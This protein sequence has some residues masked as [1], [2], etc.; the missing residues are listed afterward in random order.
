VLLAL[1]L[2]AL[3]TSDYEVPED[4]VVE[5]AA[6]VADSFIGLSFDPSG[7]PILSLERGGLL[8]LED[9]DGDGFFET[10]A[11]LTDAIAA[12]QGMYWTDGVLYAVGRVDG[13]Q[14]VHC[15]TPSAD[16][17]TIESTRLVAEVSGNGG[18]HG[19][20]AV[21]MGADGM[22][23]LMLGDHVRMTKDPVP[24]SPL[25][26][27]YEGARLPVLLDPR[28]HGHGVVYPGGFVARI[29]PASG[30]W[31]Y[32]SVGYRNAYDFAFDRNGELLT[33]DSDMEWGVGLP[34]YR[35]VRFIHSVPGGD[36]GWRKA[37]G[38][39]PSYYSDSLPALADAGRGSPTGVAYCTSE[40]F[41]ARYRD[42]LFAGDWT[43]GRIL[44]LRM[45][46][47]GAT[48]AGEVETIVS[49]NA[50][51]PVTDLAFG[52]DGALYFVSGGRG[53]VGRFER[54]VYGG[55]PGPPARGRPARRPNWLGVAPEDAAAVLS[56]SDPT[57]LRRALEALLYAEAVPREATGAICE[58][59]G[60]EDRFV[61]YA[62]M[63]V[64]RRHGTCAQPIDLRARLQHRIAAR[65]GD[66]TPS[67]EDE[68]LVDPTL[69]VDFLRAEQLRAADDAAQLDYLAELAILL[70]HSDGRV[71]R[72]LAVLLAALA[73]EGAVE[74]LLNALESEDDR[75]QQIHYAYCLSAIDA[76][77]TQS[78]LR[79]VL[80]WF[81][82]AERWTGGLSFP[83][84]LSAMRARITGLLSPEER[85]ELALKAP[86]KERVGLRTAV[87]LLEGLDAE[88][89]E[90]LVPAVQYAW[91]QADEEARLAAL[92]DLPVVSSP[93][94][95]GFLRRQ[96]ENVD[97]PR[98]AALKA[99]ARIGAADDYGRFV[100][101]LG[102]KSKDVRDAC[103][104]ALL[105]LDERPDDAAPFREALDHAR[106]LGAGRGLVYLQLFA[107]WA[108]EDVPDAPEDWNGTL[109]GWERWGAARFPGF[110]DEEVDDTRRPS[111]RFDQ[112]LA[113]LERSAERPGS[114][115]RGRD[116]F[117]RATCGSCHVVASYSSPALTGFGPDLMGV[118]RRFPLRDM[119]ETIVFPSKAIA[120]LYQTSV[121]VTHEGDVYEGRRVED[122]EHAVR[123]LQADGTHE[124]IP[125]ADVAEVRISEV[126][127]MPAGLLAPHTLE[128]VKD[129]VAFLRVDAAVEAG[130]GPEWQPLFD[131][132]TRNLWE[133]DESLWKI[134]GGVLIGRT[135]PGGLEGNE[136]ISS[137]TGFGD[138]ELELDV[139][140]SDGEGNSGV[141]Y[142]S[143]PADPADG[144]DPLG[145]QLD[146]GQT[147]W[148]S[149]YATDGRGA[150]AAPEE[151]VWR[152]VVDRGGW[153]HVY[154]RAEGARHVIEVN[155]QVTVDVMDEGFVDGSLAF[156]LH[157][158]A[159]ME[160][161]FANARI[162]ALR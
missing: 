15:M 142:R 110:T 50:G 149:L 21:A 8:R 2:I 75:A 25:A 113:Y 114:A 116:V 91:A 130:T 20:H 46:E 100:E 29:D 136:Y 83:G 4:F 65:G 79:R 72:E 120:G 64:Q 39:W 67:L 86:K 81:D 13:T 43:E 158:G 153:N 78:E 88:S 34:W 92:T 11:M 49:S 51:L 10:S 135:G 12:C 98:D 70:P 85:I 151:S 104:E 145:Y 147:I 97:A 89:V 3:D 30:E 71:S 155:G 87:S 112:T 143:G 109:A 132:D 44:V 150:L 45:R 68:V 99:V 160:V 63:R 14:G 32:H 24:G 140:L 129:L 93:K 162:R 56:D 31:T 84:Y 9:A 40:R 47:A 77:W 37:S 119:L 61:R 69:L 66:T 139:K 74:R 106:R 35:P 41:P 60:H 134:R 105:G 115:A 16:G 17:A 26:D 5:R 148:G 1:A 118:M 58:L 128:E 156:Q 90:S 126:S 28:G 154:L 33:F 123:L 6:D 94:L 27:G 18:E 157:Q 80:A 76:G 103:A 62:A 117:E 59:L 152:E 38:T 141:Q 125:L 52:P 108:G 146:L 53:T 73:P 22:L 55:E 23:Y 42:A 19:P 7:R 122:S 133:G 144:P 57:S 107:H 121:V 127:T 131:E 102:S 82:E 95:L 54:L 36:Y 124:E 48:Y 161:R 137:K 159:P 138:F 111:W 101:G 96:C